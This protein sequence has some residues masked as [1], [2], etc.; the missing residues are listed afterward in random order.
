MR[1]GGPLTF[2]VLSLCFLSQAF[3]A[4]AHAS[5]HAP[6]KAQTHAPAKTQTHA[7]ARTSSHASVSA[8]ASS[9]THASSS[10]HTSAST[11]TSSSI[12]T[13]STS[14]VSSNTHASSSTSSTAPTQTEAPAQPPG[15]TCLGTTFSSA[16]VSGAITKAG[17]Q[18]QT[19]S[20]KKTVLK[21]GGAYP[22]Q[23][24]SKDGFS[25]TSCTGTLL[26]YPL[27]SGNPYP[28]TGEPPAQRVVYQQA[29][30]KFCGCITHPP[31]SATGQKDTSFVQC[32][33]T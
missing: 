30:N 6:A 1:P 28:G 4:P 26:L 13:S 24:G 19:P 7:P 11:H 5:P 9:S 27:V 25:F 12:Q 31:V 16:D 3:A 10:V 14:H 32:T 17:V 23:Y 15:C 29:D 21:K 8:H 33:S 18:A 22:H 20:G 2:I